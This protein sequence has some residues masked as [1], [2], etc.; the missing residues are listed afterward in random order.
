MR[1]RSG[2]TFKTTHRVAALERLVAQGELLEVSVEGLRW[3]CYMRSTDRPALEQVLGSQAP[4][5]CAA[6][7]APLDNLMWDRRYLRE[8][9]DFEYLWEV[10]KPVAERRW[11]Y[12]VLPILYGDRFVAR[13]EPGRDKTSDA[14]TIQNW[15]W[16][17]DVQ[18][19]DAMRT[20]LRDCFAR[21]LGFLGRETLQIGQ[22]TLE[23]GD[24]G[25]LVPTSRSATD[26]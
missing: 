20:A 24:L 19:T 2:S 12:Y 3:P 23:Q 9:F 5:P 17:R 26:A 7:L 18:P 22:E 25:F 21:F 1:V 11:G 8:M 4:A 15:W 13:F 14:L 10:Y 16:E 6:I